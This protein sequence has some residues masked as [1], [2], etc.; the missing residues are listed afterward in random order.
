[1]SG[2]PCP[3]RWN[4]L[5][6]CPACQP[7]ETTIQDL[8]QSAAWEPREHWPYTETTKGALVFC[9]CGAQLT[10]DTSGQPEVWQCSKKP[11]AVP[12]IPADPCAELRR[13]ILIKLALWESVDA[14]GKR[15]RMAAYQEI[16]G[17]MNDLNMRPFK[18]LSCGTE[19]PTVTTAHQPRFCGRLCEA[20]V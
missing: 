1:M 3:H 12:P 11:P 20:K 10:H 16:L 8:R 17:V 9:G 6:P 19:L 2:P 13:F 15:S 7:G 4:A 18:C 14:M 5:R